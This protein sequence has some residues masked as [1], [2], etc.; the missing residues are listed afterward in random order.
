MSWKF[1]KLLLDENPDAIL[2]TTLEGE[3]LFW[4]KG[5]ESVFGFTSS[6]TVGRF[7]SETIVPSDK[8][9]EEETILQKTLQTPVSNYESFRRKKDGSLVYVN[10][11]S[12]AIRDPNGAFQFILQSTK[13]VT[14]RKVQRD[15]GLL[16][17][18]FGE[19]IE[20][21]PDAIVM[22]DVT[23][24]IVLVNTQAER[25]FGYGPGELL[26][27]LVEALIPQRY[28]ATHVGHRAAYLEQPRRRAM[29][30][31][32]ELYGLRKNGQE[33]PVEISLSPLKTDEGTFVMS[34]I[35]DITDRK[36]FERELQAKNAQLAAANEELE[37]FSYSISHDLR[38]PVRAMGGFAHI[39]SKRLGDELPA[40]S[41]HALDRIRD[42]A[43]RMSQLI[44]GLLSF[45]S[46]SK[47]PLVKKTLSVEPIVRT[48][49]EELRGEFANRRVNVEIGELPM[50]EADSTL[51][52]QVYTNLLSNAIKYT[53]DRD[54]AIIKIGSRWEDGRFIYF[55]K[56]NG[57]GFDMQ[58]AG[59]LF[60]VFQRLHSQ[61]EF[62]GTG[63]GLAIVQRIIHRHGGGVWAEA[64]ENRGAAFYFTLNDSVKA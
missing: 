54:P 1:D 12:K 27:S 40:E 38:A 41:K 59:K 6:E 53:R 5:A 16:Q 19:F 25:V 55:V 29:G 37:S 33:F 32:L 13:D 28:A 2:A 17:A 15:S 52:Q 39:L 49:L 8:L 44:D 63:V 45:S 48:V 58:Y 36:R 34:A 43:A 23:G 9:H 56:D 10:I 46:L 57:T 18:K 47:Q 11:S 21:T 26:G 62:E 7:L 24:H 64:Q 30:A 3:I 31:G 14:D 4:N 61:Q 20:S 51:L 35:R 60:G 42:N 22:S 50:C